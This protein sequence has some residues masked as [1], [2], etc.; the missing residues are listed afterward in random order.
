MFFYDFL[1]LLF[2]AH[3]LVLRKRK[4]ATQTE[5]LHGSLFYTRDYFYTFVILSIPLLECLLKAQFISSSD[6]VLRMLPVLPPSLGNHI[7][8]AIKNILH[9]DYTS[10][11]IHNSQAK[12][13]IFNNLYSF[14]SPLDNLRCLSQK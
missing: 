3:L 14:V 10:L 2:F 9:I 11:F 6:K 7:K 12:S 5:N 1:L 4:E 13:L 8:Y